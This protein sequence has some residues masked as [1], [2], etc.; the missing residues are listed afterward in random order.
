MPVDRTSGAVVFDLDGTLVETA[1]DLIGAV[2]AVAARE[3][4]PAL[5]PVAERAVA[6]QGG[7]ALLRRAMALASRPPDEDR[8]TA[9][10]PHFLEAY[11]ASI[12]DLSHLYEGAEACLDA[13]EAAGRAVAICTNKPEAL[14]RLLLDKLGV[15]HRFPV[16]LG[17]DTLPVRKPDP[18]HLTETLARLGVAPA[19]SIMVGDTTT[20]QSTATAATVPFVFA[21]YGYADGD[22]AA[23]RS[24][25]AIDGL[26]DLPELVRRLLG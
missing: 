15:L 26:R 7:R 5:D 10:L 2:N 22:E 16:M 24:G 19:R 8:V 12:A 9:L 4:W 1:P 21:A 13:L 11:E 20:D 18:R 3:G 17:A 25:H 23:L 6:G 14:A